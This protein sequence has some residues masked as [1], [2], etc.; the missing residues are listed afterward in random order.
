MSTGTPDRIDVHQLD[1]VVCV[2]T[3]LRAGSGLMSSL[4][5]DHPN[6]L[7]M[8]DDIIMGFYGFWD[9]HGHRPASELVSSFLDY[10]AVLFDAWSLC[11]CTRVPPQIGDLLNWTSLGPERDETLH[12]DQEIFRR[13]MAELIG[14]DKPVSRRLFFQACHVAYAEA[15]GRRVTNPQIV[16]GLHVA[17]PHLVEKFFEDFPNGQFLQMIRDPIS[18]LGSQFRRY[19]MSG[20]LS[21][22]TAANLV[23]RI[24][25]PPWVPGGRFSQWRGVRLEDLHRNPRETMESVCEW[26]QF[27]WDDTLLKS[28]VNGKQWWN[29]K[30]RPQ[31][32]GPNEAIVTQSHRDYIT[33]FDRFRLKVLSAKRCRADGYEVRSRYKWLVTRLLVLPLLMIPLKIE[34]VSVVSQRWGPFLSGLT[35]IDPR[36]KPLKSRIFDALHALYQGRRTMLGAWL[37]LFTKE[38]DRIEVISNGPPK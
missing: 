32:T 37:R 22:G 29:E 15:L 16:F 9:T 13:V 17:H 2:M 18:D 21:P 30:D 25:G 20:Y 23:S 26:L 11:K 6:L 36:T 10:Y 1:R 24:L 12:V 34:F 7:S 27:P 8:P 19:G 28:T 14:T 38:F 35:T 31:V 5:D 3:Q 4:L 33:A